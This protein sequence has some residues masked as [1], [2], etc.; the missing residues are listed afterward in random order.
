VGG[1]IFSGDKRPTLLVIGLLFAYLTVMIIKPIRTFFEV[2][3]LPPFAY[4]IIGVVVV[5]WTFVLRQAWHGNWFERFLR[6][7]TV[8]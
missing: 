4:L 2:L 3:I 1:D 8:R 6:L 7:E 5:L